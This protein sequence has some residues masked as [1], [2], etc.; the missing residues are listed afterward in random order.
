MFLQEGRGGD[1]W[2]SRFTFWSNLFAC[3]IF[4]SFLNLV[5][6]LE[7]DIDMYLTL[8]VDLV[9]KLVIIFSFDLDFNFNKFHI[10]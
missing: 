9:S 2:R 6:P 7:L 10:V 1:Y 5:L 4:F 3:E 8:D